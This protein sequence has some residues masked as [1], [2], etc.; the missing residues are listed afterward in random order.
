MQNDP[1]ILESLIRRFRRDIWSSVT[2]DAVV[3][4]GV[5]VKDFG[6][7]Q[8][9][10]F[11]DMPFAS[12]LNQIHGAAEPGAVT[13]G[14]LAEALEWIWP[15]EVDFRVPVAMC[16]PEAKLAEELLKSCGC[17]PSPSWAMYVRGAEPPEPLKTNVRV[18][19]LGREEWEGEGLSQLVTEAMGYPITTGS[20]LYSVHTRPGWR[21]YTAQLGRHGSIC[22]TGAM[23]ID[24][25]IA[26]LGAETTLEEARKRGCN[27]ALL[28][29][30]I[31]DAIDAGC[32]TI[33]L[34][35]ACE[36]PEDVVALH[37][38][39]KFFG[40]EVAYESRVWKQPALHPAW[41]G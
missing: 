18:W 11:G 41:I 1:E 5:Q 30:R 7:V 27:K 24:G 36:M 28:H 26:V 12:M 6:P 2:R 20:L 34:E 23:M 33:M 8:V 17:E 40:F 35:A 25:D 10:T 13:K 31:L 38:N 21:G 37:K 4:S 32:T 3:E 14:Y 22:A 19:G 29:R 39:L 9:V 15:W 16:R